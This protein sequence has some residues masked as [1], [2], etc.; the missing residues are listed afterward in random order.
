[1][2]PATAASVPAPN[3]IGAIPGADSAVPAI[4]AK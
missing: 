1:V 4:P 2:V 3:A